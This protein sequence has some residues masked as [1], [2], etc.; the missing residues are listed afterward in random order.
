MI[1]PR[2]MPDIEFP[3]DLV[4]IVAAVVAAK[5]AVILLIWAARSI[6]SDIRS[7]ANY[8]I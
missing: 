7:R 4:S 1:E 5:V 6:F 8:K 3:I 2:T